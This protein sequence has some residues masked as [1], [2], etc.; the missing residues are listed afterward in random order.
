MLKDAHYGMLAREQL[1][2]EQAR[3]LTDDEHHLVGELRQ[4]LESRDSASVGALAHVIER[5]MGELNLLK[6][7]FVGDDGPDVALHAA[8]D[9]TSTDDLARPLSVTEINA[10]G[11]MLSRLN[12]TSG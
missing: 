7:Q 10:L 2:V 1:D 12:R 4:V 8:S 5:L 11:Q 3:E 6:S 9:A